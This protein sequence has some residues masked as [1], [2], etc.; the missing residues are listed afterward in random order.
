MDFHRPDSLAAAT[1]LLAASP[2][3]LL[4]GG[5]DVFP[6][7]RDKPLSGPVLDLSGIAELRSIRETATHFVLGATTTWSDVIN[8]NLPTAFNAL[9]QAAREVGSIQIQNRGTLAGNICNASPAADGV[10]PL[11]ALDAE[12]AIASSSA[13]RVVPLSQ[14]ILGNRKTTLLPN[15]LLTEIRIPKK[16]AKGTSTFQKL[17]ARRYL[18]ISIAMVA[19]RLAQNEGKI[20]DCAIAVGACS[21]VAQR[22]RQLE[23]VLIGKDVREIVHNNLTI[24]MTTLDALAPIDD[25]RAPANYR[26]EAVSELIARAVQTT[27]KALA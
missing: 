14:V 26:L 19:V 18:V 2:I 4:A 10:P 12:I 15:E 11:L 6:S 16:S 23:H 24:E 3:R 27:A 22:L 1:H 20:S 5:T 8:A 25:I 7:L 17:G 9:K 21:E 13:T